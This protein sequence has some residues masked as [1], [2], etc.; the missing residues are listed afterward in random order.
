MK[1][2]VIIPV[3]KRTIIILPHTINGL[4][5]HADSIGKIIVIGNSVLKNNIEE[6]GGT[7]VDEDLLFEGMTYKRV[8]TLLKLRN[9]LE[10]R[11]GWYFQQF[12][13]MAYAYICADEYYMVWDSDLILLNDMRFFDDNVL[14]YM[15]I[16][17]EYHLPYFSTINRL[18]GYGQVKR[19]KDCSYISE[20]MVIKKEYMLHMLEAICSNSKTGE[21]MFY[22]IIID[23]IR[24]FDIPGS[25][26]S[27]FET[28]GN[29]IAN[30]YPGSYCI[31]INRTLREGDLFIGAEPSNKELEWASKSFDLISL[32]CRKDRIKEVADNINSLMTDNSLIEV[33][34]QYAHLIEY[35]KFN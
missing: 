33:V 19:I 9:C 2:D 32:E 27:E 3:S 7:F 24:G 30:K 28:Y 26:F 8:D 15:D 16:K 1:F 10:R 14:P 22:E 18:F 17:T 6:C 21:K 12:L 25:G 5:R 23:S 31:R 34:K 13:K 4:L 20:H 11:T 29:Y 35:E